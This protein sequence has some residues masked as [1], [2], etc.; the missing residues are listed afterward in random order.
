MNNELML[1]VQQIIV[2]QGSVEFSEYENI[3]HQAQKLAEQ[4]EKVEVTEENLKESKKLLATVNK[5]V[6]ELEEKRISVKKV[7]LEPYNLFEEQVKNIVTV[8]KNAD[9][10]VRQQI[11]RLEEIERNEKEEVLENIF[12][13]R[14]RMYSLGDLIE[15]EDFIKSK[16]LNKTVSIESVEKE[17]IDFLEKTEK[18]YQ[19]I[20]SLDEPEK[21]VSV[22][23]CC[24]DLANAISHVQQQR[25]R[26]EQIKASGTIKLQ[27][28]ENQ[29]AY[30]VNVQVYNQK[31]LKLLEMI[32]QQNGFEFT[33]DK[34]VL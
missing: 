1:D 11:K 24:F 25:Q 28:T 22:Y 27:P 8:V 20:L 34:V 31:E 5:R 15:F 4:I 14:K 7:M 23:I 30:L 9:V 29:I 19:V 32:L 16:H 12:Y 18:D 21:I 3:F 26:E 13:K 33:T 10:E 2:I 6:K 17:M